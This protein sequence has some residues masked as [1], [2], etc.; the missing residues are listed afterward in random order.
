MK[1][2]INNFS[3]GLADSDKLGIK[4]SFA[5]GI[6][7]DIHSSPAILKVNQALKKESGTVITDFCKWAIPCSD[8]NSYWFGDSGN[9]YK[10]TSAGV[11]SVVYTDSGGEIKGAAEFD[12][13]IYWATNTALHEINVGGTWTGTASTV[14][15]VSG[16]PATLNSATYH[17]MVVQGLYLLIGNGQ[18]IAT[19]EAGTGIFTANGTPDVSLADL[20]SNYEI[21]TLI[22]FGIDVLVGTTTNDKYTSARIF[23]WDVASPA[24]ISD[25]DIPDYGINAFIPVDNYTFAQA[26]QAGNIYQYTGKELVLKH[27]MNGD[28]SAKTM[29]VLPQSHTS[30]RGLPLF[31]VSNVSGNPIKQGIYSLGRHDH[32]YPLALNLEYVISTGD[33]SDVSIGAL[34]TIGN[35][36]LVAWKD[37]TSYGVD[38][39][40]WA[41]KYAN[42]YYKT[43]ILDGGARQLIKDFKN[44]A[45][46]YKIKP[47]GT[48]ITAKYYLNGGSVQTLTTNDDAIGM[49]KW[50]QETLTGGYIQLEVDFTTLGNDAPELEEI[51]IDLD[52][53]DTL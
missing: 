23:R 27:K 28:Y 41:N 53:K 10:R 50:A 35:D 39:I 52:L 42:A 48:D 44:F 19:I 25:D 49:K 16:F 21:R 46:N 11:W 36:L 15:A 17:P 1:Y 5:E 12:G 31:G 18:Q 2:K 20:P 40:D 34:L 4:G 13:Y 8:G 30:F 51:Y 47:S 22:N 9:I 38:I 45:F 43:L 33:T 32:K 37:G 7:L 6:G 24:Y 26:G 29:E 14:D 3:G